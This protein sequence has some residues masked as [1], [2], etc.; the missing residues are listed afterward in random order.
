MKYIIPKGWHYSIHPPRLYLGIKRKFKIKVKFTDSCRYTINSVDQK[1]V[2]K[3]FGVGLTLNHHIYSIRIG[4]NYDIKNDRIVLFHYTYENT[5][6][7]YSPFDFIKINE[8]YEI[9]LE[10]I[11]NYFIVSTSGCYCT[12]KYDYPEEVLGF[13]LYPNFGGN[14]VS[15]HKM[16]V[17]MSIN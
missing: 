1:D 4:W 10:L 2:N 17:E 6:R 12:V 16:I 14:I 7:K 9:E 3:L 13:Y 15:P 8:E 11:D 5:I